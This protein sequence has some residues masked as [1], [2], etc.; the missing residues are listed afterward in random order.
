MAST[1]TTPAT[2]SIEVTATVPQPPDDTDDNGYYF[3]NSD[4]EDDVYERAEPWERYRK[5]NNSRVFY[6]IRIGEVLN[7]RYRVE[8]KLGYGG[9]STVWMA[10]DLLK[11]TD[12]ALKI[13]CAGDFGEHEFLMQE[14]ILQN[15][16]DTSHLVTYLATFCL[17]GDGCNHR[18]L[19]FPL[20]GPAVDLYASRKPMASRMSAARQL[21]MALDSL[22]KAGI[23]HRDLN[24]RN[25]MWGIKPL[26]RLSRGDKYK[27]IGRPLKQA[28]THIPDLWKPGELVV[29]LTVP[30][31]LR[32]EMFYLGDFGQATQIGSEAPVGSPP[33]AY[34]SP[35]RIHN[36]APTP[37]CDMWSYMCIFMKLYFGFVPFHAYWEGGVIT[38]IVRPGG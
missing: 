9:F 5:N 25:C 27:K 38:S 31:E 32:T 34:C 17:C 37:A 2:T 26:D 11:K 4:E 14:K 16:Q 7:Q 29:P 8:H 1:G 19:V 36:K 15:V 12:V 28:I 20:R 18:V 23:V 22:H 24:S 33:V 6:P 3:G 21:L 35:E 30:E 13:M 10:H